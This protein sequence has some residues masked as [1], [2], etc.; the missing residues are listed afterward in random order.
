M[1]PVNNPNNDQVAPPRDWLKKP[2]FWGLFCLC[3]ATAV[4]ASEDNDLHGVAINFAM[5][6]LTTVVTDNRSM[7]ITSATAGFFGYA[8]N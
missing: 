1:M 7:L 2:E 8:L 6:A 4:A 5:L 3:L